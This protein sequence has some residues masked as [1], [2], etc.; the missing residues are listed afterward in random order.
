MLFKL[1]I[2]S[3]ASV[4]G[5]VCQCK[6]IPIALSDAILIFDLGIVPKAWHFFFF[7]IKRVK[8]FSNIIMREVT[9]RRVRTCYSLIGLY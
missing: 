5:R 2:N 8:N 6:H 4:G 7:F 3:Y 9:F 1:I